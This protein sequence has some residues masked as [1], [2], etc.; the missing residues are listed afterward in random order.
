VVDRIIRRVKALLDG[1][2]EGLHVRAVGAETWIYGPSE[3]AP[4]ELPAN[5]RY[6]G[7]HRIADIPRIPSNPRG[8]RE[9]KVYSSS[10]LAVILRRLCDEYEGLYLSDVRR[11]LEDSL[12]AWLPEFLYDSEDDHVRDGPPPTEFEVTEMSAQVQAL[13]GRLT[14]SHIAVLVGKSN[15]VSDTRLAAQ[16]GCSR[17]TII[18]YRQEYSDMLG[19]FLLDEVP[20]ERHGAAIEILLD[21]AV[22]RNVERS[23]DRP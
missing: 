22:D 18:K 15:G 10:E 19:R 2:P 13:L 4:A 6:R 1:P 17:P 23:D 9:S 21:Q 11:I 16:L 5:D 3:R 20:A 7:A 12:T 8:A 14:D